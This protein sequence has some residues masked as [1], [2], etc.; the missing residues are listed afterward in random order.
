MLRKGRIRLPDHEDIWRVTTE[1]AR[2]RCGLS[3]HRR[4]TR[5]RGGGRRIGGGEKDDE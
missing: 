5:R 4:R 3:H 2:A 1:E